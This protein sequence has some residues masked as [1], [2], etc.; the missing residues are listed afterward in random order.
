MSEEDL[1]QVIKS[2]AD[3]L[4]AIAATLEVLVEL[5]VREHEDV[6]PG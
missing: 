3:S 6:G 4:A 2:M 5:V 1:Q